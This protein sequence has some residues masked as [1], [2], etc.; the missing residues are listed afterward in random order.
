MCGKPKKIT[1]D[2]CEKTSSSQAALSLH[3]KTHDG[4][5]RKK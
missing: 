5:C 4:V 3:K 2:K 1:C